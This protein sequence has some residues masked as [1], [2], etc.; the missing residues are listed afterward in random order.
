[1]RLWNSLS[2]HDKLIK[3][4]GNE[5]KLRLLLQQLEWL[6]CCCYWP[7]RGDYV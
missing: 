7:K 6:P 4:Q 5:I 3:F 2:W 1:V